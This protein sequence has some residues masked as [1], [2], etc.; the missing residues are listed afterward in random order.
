MITGFTVT[1]SSLHYTAQARQVLVLLPGWP[2]GE[3]LPL[4]PW[5]LTVQNLFLNLGCDDGVS[6][7]LGLLGVALAGHGLESLH[8]SDRSVDIQL[9][10]DL[11]EN[12]N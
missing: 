12:M 11:T 9:D 7:E 2:G 4:H 8:R 1:L 3:L 5:L 10:S 6:V